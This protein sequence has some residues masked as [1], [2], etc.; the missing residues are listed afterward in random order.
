MRRKTRQRLS[1]VILVVILT[2][3]ALLYIYPVA[4]ISIRLR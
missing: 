1:H 2:V 3:I 4:L